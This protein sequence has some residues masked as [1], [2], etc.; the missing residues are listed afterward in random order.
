MVR[1]MW[2]SGQEGKETHR[3]GIMRLW[4]HQDLLTES[5]YIVSTG[6]FPGQLCCT[7]NVKRVRAHTLLFALLGRISA[8]S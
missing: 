2:T 1:T 7:L 5:V 8:F 4:E 6:T 3:G